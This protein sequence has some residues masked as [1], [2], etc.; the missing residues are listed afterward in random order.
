M[1]ITLRMVYADDWTP[2]VVEENYLRH[3]EQIGELVTEN[4]DIV[5]SLSAGIL[6]PW[7]E[8]HNDDDYVMAANKSYRRKDRPEYNSHA[9]TTDIDSPEQGARRYRLVKHLLD[10]TPDTIAVAVRYT[11][12]LMEIK[13]LAK[14]PPRGAAALTQTQLDRLGLHDDSFASFVMSHTRGGGWQEAFYP[15]WDNGKR[16][17]QAEDVAAFS[18]RLETSYGGDVLQFGETAWYPDDY[19][20][21]DTDDPLN[22]T[23]AL[24]AGAQLALNEAAARKLTMINRSWNTRH[25]EFWKR[26]R[27]RASGNDPAESA[28]TRL[29][30][31]LGYRL[32]LGTAGF[33]TAAKSGD[34]FNITAVIYNDGWAGIVRA[35]PVFVVFDNG[36][37]RYDI[38][39][40]DV[41]ARTWRSGENR[42]AASAALPADME[43][44]TYAVALWLP[45]YY[46]NLRGLPEYSVRFANKGIW[47]E[48]KG[49]NYLGA[50]EYR[51][52]G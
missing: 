14:N 25:L 11:E 33:T 6:G 31:K 24:D 22:N 34:L 8:W 39:L 28:Y 48:S 26:T 38:E 35:R 49:Y 12:F 5:E 13:A 19:P 37:N 36:V 17:G 16:Y 46:E 18:A 3:I 41:D 2:M 30:R 10:H 50:L 43:A 45:D 20:G 47:R 15:Y 32:R 44:G 9:P 1:K 52:D 21:F 23:R 42:L 4:A 27:L 40:A 51:G 7:G 29:D